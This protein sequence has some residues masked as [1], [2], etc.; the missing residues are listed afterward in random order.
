IISAASTPVTPQTAI[1]VT[2]QWVTYESS[3]ARTTPTS[4]RSSFSSSPRVTHTTDRSG[5]RPV[6]KALGI[7]EFDTATLGFVESESWQSRSTIV[8]SSGASSAE[9]SRPPM[10]R[11]A[12]LS[13]K[14]HWKKNAPALTRTAMMTPPMFWPTIHQIARMSTT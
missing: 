6:A 5:E 1:T 8:W 4:Y 11:M 9:T 13:E 3:W 14:Y 10:A 12:I 7:A 2:P